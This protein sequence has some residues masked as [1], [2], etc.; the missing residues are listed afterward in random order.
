MLAYGI[1]D[2]TDYPCRLVIVH[3]P[4]GANQASLFRGFADD[5][6]WIDRDAVTTDPWARL[7][8]IYTWVVISQ[9]N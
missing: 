1:F 2:L 9:A 4:R 7:Q 8:D 6:P 5:K 3:F